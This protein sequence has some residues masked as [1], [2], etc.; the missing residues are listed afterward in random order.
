MERAR[1]A[2]E[3]AGL[4]PFTRP[5]WA[6]AI[7]YDFARAQIEPKAGA[8]DLEACAECLRID[9]PIVFP[10]SDLSA[11]REPVAPGAF[12]LGPAK[13]RVGREAFV[14]AAS[15]VIEYIRAGDVYQV[16]LAH[17]LHAAFT[18]DTRAAFIAMAQRARPA[19]GAYLELEHRAAL[20]LSP[21][22]FL[23][24]DPATRIVTTRPMKGTRALGPGAEA[25]LRTS[26]K[27]RAELAMITDLMRND[28]GRVC[29]FGSM[30]VTEPRTL[31]HHAGVVQTV[32]QVQ[33]RLRDGLHA[34][35]LVAAVFP[36]GSVTG[37]PKV[38][39]MQIIRELEPHARGL[40][41]GAMGYLTDEGALTLSIAIR[42]A[43]IDLKTS[44]LEY[45]V[46]AGI[47]A[48]SDPEEEWRE[49][50]AKAW[51]LL[52]ATTLEDAP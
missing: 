29:E 45:P 7:G 40:Y 19:F 16:N 15:R 35:D 41:C 38:R 28:L 26:E 9:A 47:V 33:G 25:S 11:A 17:P 42:T 31:E 34:R 14:R 8:H 39:A 52:G 20:S 10:P 49:T 50:L 3:A 36:G 21:E 44:T 18:G 48:D 51:P 23:T 32:S 30:R 6:L 27:D 46:G 1:P 5:G 43:T 4:H 37:A 12:T 13:S 24:Y 22:A 2:G